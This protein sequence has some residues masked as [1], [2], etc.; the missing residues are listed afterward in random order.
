MTVEKAAKVILAAGVVCVAF[1]W[2]PDNWPVASLVSD[3]YAN[4]ATSLLSIA[5]TV[6]L[7]DRLQ[8]RRDAF[9]RK[10]QL[11]RE[12]GSSDRATAVRAAKE[13]NVKGWLADGSLRQVDLGLANLEGAKLENAKLVGV[14]LS[15]AN[16]KQVDL[17]K[18]DLSHANLE[19]CTAEGANFKGACLS[20]ANLRRT[21]L[22]RAT[23][24]DVDMTGQIDLLKA[25]FIRASL[26]GAKLMGARLE[27]CD[28]LE[29]DLSAAD[30]T[31]AKLMG[32]DIT[33]A[34]L[35][36]AVLERVDFSEVIGW[37]EVASMANARI[38]GMR[39]APEGF[40]QLALSKGAVE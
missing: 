31:E 18:A 26:R 14:N 1:Y 19:E 20:G 37:E 17:Q 5:L 16:L 10:G 28:L 24:D 9:E 21:A 7:I 15:F 13:V 27:E 39:N 29:C 12:M 6:L 11:L 8:S 30:L 3:L 36:G 2:Y 32:A 4:V 22:S 33:R 35:D 34:K 23:M 40:R 38:A 25:S